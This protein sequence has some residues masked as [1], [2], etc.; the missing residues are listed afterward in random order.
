VKK[1]K[2]LYELLKNKYY[3]FKRYHIEEMVFYDI[4]GLSFLNT[5]YPELHSKNRLN[6]EL[7]KKLKTKLKDFIDIN[8]SKTSASIQILRA[9]ND[10]NFKIIGFI[11]FSINMNELAHE[12]FLDSGVKTKFIFKKDIL[13][14]NLDK[15]ILK[16]YK[17]SNLANNFMYKE[18]I[19]NKLLSN[20]EHKEL[21]ENK[22]IKS[23]AFGFVFDL[24]NKKVVTSFLPLFDT[25]DNKIVA[26]L[27]SQSNSDKLISFVLKR[28]DTLVFICLF[29]CFFYLS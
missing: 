29:F 27:V 24:E 7:L 5:K 14:K 8:V 20:E 6:E 21:I 25:L 22:T 28:F 23:E 19:Y 15:Q 17:L 9:I 3:Y 12:I 26:Y 2:K 13:E 18:S 10:E 4:E 11:G 1:K 16:Q